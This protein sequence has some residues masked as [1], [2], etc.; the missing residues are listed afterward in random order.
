MTARKQLSN[1]ARVLRKHPGVYARQGSSGTWWI[2]RL[3][4]LGEWCIA[5][6]PTP[7]L[8]WAAATRVM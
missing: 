3:S 5:T 4:S 7:A 1:K 6:G 2:Y 8:A